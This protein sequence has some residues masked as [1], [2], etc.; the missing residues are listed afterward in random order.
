MSLGSWMNEKILIVFSKELKKIEKYI[1][2]LK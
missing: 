2:K 1:S